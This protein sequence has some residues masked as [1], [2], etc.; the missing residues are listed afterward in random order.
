VDGYRLSYIDSDGNEANPTIHLLSAD[1]DQND[2]L[3]VNQVT[4]MQGD[5]KR[6][7][8]IVLYC[9]GMPV[10]IIELKKAGSATADLPAAHAQLQTYLREF[11]MAF[12]FCVFTLASDGI[13]AKYG[14][15]FTPL[16][17]FSPWNVDDDGVPVAPDYMEDGEAVTAGDRAQ[18]P[19]QPGTFRPAGGQFHRVRR[20]P[21]RAEQADRQAPPVFRRDQGRGQHHPG[22]G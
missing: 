10:S 4:L 2:W 18:R 13:Q 8:D 17:Y 11:P 14:T 22:G 5:Y 9:N 1:A 3:A 21:G 12:R 19:V 15:P 20:R 16:N 6:R 7:F